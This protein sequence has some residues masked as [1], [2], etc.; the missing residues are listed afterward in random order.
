[1]FIVFN[2]DIRYSI[3]NKRSDVMKPAVL[4]YSSRRFATNRDYQ[5][6][7][8]TELIKFYICSIDSFH[9]DCII[10]MLL[11]FLYVPCERRYCDCKSLNLWS[12]FLRYIV[13]IINNDH[14]ECMV[15][16]FGARGARRCIVGNTA[17]VEPSHSLHFAHSTLRRN[18]ECV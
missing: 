16:I 4:L 7:I 14:P 11:F 2:F 10:K 17:N 1:M 6:S 13:I 8:T 15:G 12:S 9:S 3:S 18:Q 5:I